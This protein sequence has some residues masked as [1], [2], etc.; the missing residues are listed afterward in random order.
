MGA[1]SHRLRLLL[2]QVLVCKKVDTDFLIVTIIDLREAGWLYET[3]DPDNTSLD[4][5]NQLLCQPNTISLWIMT[6]DVLKW[7]RFSRDV[8]SSWGSLD[9]CHNVQDTKLWVTYER[10]VTKYST[11]RG[12]SITWNMI[13]PCKGREYCHVIIKRRSLD[14]LL[15]ESIWSQ[16]DRHRKT[17]QITETKSGVVG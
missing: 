3:V 13:Q 16:Q 17:S 8:H 7:S 2:T 11:H 1:A 10:W 12:R 5:R 9:H 14:I 6:S 15:G 4:R